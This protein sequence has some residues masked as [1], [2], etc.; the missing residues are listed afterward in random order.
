MMRIPESGIHKES[1]ININK[2]FRGAAVEGILKW[3]QKV[4][5]LIGTVSNHSNADEF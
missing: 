4:G 2:D 3:Y 5:R 1:F